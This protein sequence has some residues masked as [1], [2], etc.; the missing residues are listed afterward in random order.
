MLDVLTPPDESRGFVLRREALALGIDDNALARLVKAGELVRIRQGAYAPR[1]QWLDH[2]PRQRHVVLTHAVQAQYDDHVVVS[3]VS[4]AVADGAPDWGLDLTDVHLT[5][6]EGGGRRS[7]GIVH[8]EGSLRVVDVS[9]SSDGW[10]TTPTRTLL[11]CCNIVTT[12]VGLVLANWYLHH[13]LTTIDELKVRYAELQRSR[14]ML[15]VRLV[16]RLADRR[17]ESV[18]ESRFLY[19]VWRAGLPLPVPQWEVWDGDRLVGV[20]DFAWPELGLMAEFDGKIKYGR[21]LR[22]GQSAGD[23][24]FAEK[25][26][27]DELREITGFRMIRPIWSDLD[28]PDVTA[29]RVRRMLRRAA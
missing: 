8:H 21:L 17:I 13:G 2:S 27:E 25:C 22:P 6:L 23:A 29:D 5:H 28:R 20:V 11:D 19:L 16:L 12:E 9:R 1:A 3:H 7:A 18:G 15:P 24:V 10:F 26:R 4:Q 14:R